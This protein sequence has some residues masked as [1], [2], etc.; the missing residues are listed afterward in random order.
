M[1]PQT[2]PWA[3]RPW[4]HALDNPSLAHALDRPSLAHALDRPSLA[5]ALDGPSL[6][7]CP[8]QPVY[9]YKHVAY[10]MVYF[11]AKDAFGTL[12]DLQRS[13]S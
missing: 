11:R 5:H 8:G 1:A 6:A 12:D 4:P 3:I 10:V 9:R 13:I 2:Q 7:S